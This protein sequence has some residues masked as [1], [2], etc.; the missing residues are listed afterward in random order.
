M[1]V[2]LCALYAWQILRRLLR[3]PSNPSLRRLKLAEL[4]DKVDGP[5]L[6][7]LKNSGFK[8]ESNGLVMYI[9]REIKCMYIDIY[10]CMFSLVF[11]L[12]I[13]FVLIHTLLIY[14][15]VLGYFVCPSARRRTLGARSCCKG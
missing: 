12:D 15:V 9:K 1:F 10:I 4:K 2:C 13:L 6:S 14:A 7:T 8:E 3:E 5:A 11:I